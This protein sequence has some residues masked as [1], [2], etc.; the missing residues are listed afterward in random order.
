MCILIIN[1]IFFLIFLVYISNLQSAK[2]LCLAGFQ[3]WMGELHL[4]GNFMWSW[5]ST[6]YLIQTKNYNVKIV[7]SEVYAL[8]VLCSVLSLDGK[9]NT[10]RISQLC[11]SLT[12]IH[13]SHKKSMKYSGHRKLLCELSK[14]SKFNV[15]IL[16]GY[17]KN[18]DASIL[19][20][21]YRPGR[22]GFNIYAENTQ[23]KLTF[24][25]L[26]PWIQTAIKVS[27]LGD[28]EVSQRLDL[29]Q[30]LPH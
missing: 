12:W 27:R 20:Y 18:T 24:L 30:I 25:T 4:S 2:P 9:V 11:H 6:Y 16:L 15:L 21:K 14:L 1:L 8:L 5:C 29:T 17:Q 10:R 26:L 22:T 7:I 23:L 3:R 19:V 28:F 13:L